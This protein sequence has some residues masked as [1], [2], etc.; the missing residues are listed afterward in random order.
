MKF[1][2]FSKNYYIINNESCY[3]IYGG[4]GG[5]EDSWWVRA[6]EIPQYKYGFE[7]SLL[8]IKLHQPDILTHIERIQNEATS[9][10][11]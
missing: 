6:T 10:S 2:K 3:D 8:W 7:I 9:N 5:F 4:F 11:I 1:Y